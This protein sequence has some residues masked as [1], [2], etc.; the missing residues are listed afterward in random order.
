MSYNHTLS[1][2]MSPTKRVTVTLPADLVDEIDRLETNRSRFVAEG[3]RREIERRRR[4]SLR[5]SLR[6]P[7]ADCAEIAEEGLDAWAEGLS[8]ET[9]SDLI[10]D[11]RGIAVR[12]VAGEGWRSDDA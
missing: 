3:V 2:S 11:S 8:D 7:H 4:E 6:S 12:W 10:D 5:E 1:K 9:S